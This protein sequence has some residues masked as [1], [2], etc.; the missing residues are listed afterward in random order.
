MTR[1]IDR[2]FVV[3]ITFG[4]IGATFLIAFSGF[5]ISMGVILAIMPLIC[6]ITAFFFSVRGIIKFGIHKEVEDTK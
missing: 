3:G 5:L 4:F 2:G 6:G 1:V